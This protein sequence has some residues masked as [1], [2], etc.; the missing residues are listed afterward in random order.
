MQSHAATWQ[1]ASRAFWSLTMPLD[2]QGEPVTGPQSS[3]GSLMTGKVDFYIGET[4][5]TGSISL[6]LAQHGVQT[7]FLTPL[8][9]PPCLQDRSNSAI[10]PP[11]AP[12]VWKLDKM[13]YIEH[14]AQR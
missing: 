6:T 7:S 14:T 2:F 1:T 3:L 9:L 8:S 10:L 4:Q 11:T 5:K 12:P 13:T